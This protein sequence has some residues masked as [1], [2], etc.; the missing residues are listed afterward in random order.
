[1]P[2]G[3]I[4][5]P[6]WPLFLIYEPM[7]LQ[8]CHLFCCEKLIFLPIA[9]RFHYQERI[10]L[11]FGPSNFQFLMRI[12]EWNTVGCFCCYFNRCLLYARISAATSPFI[13]LR[14][15]DSA[16]TE[17]LFVSYVKAWA[18]FWT[19][20]LV[21]DSHSCSQSAPDDRLFDPSGCHIAPFSLIRTTAA[22]TLLQLYDFDA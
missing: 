11:L 8:L 22:T 1:M 2:L 3:P 18:T 17:A 4:L 21:D 6:S 20:K 10:S 12:L 15:A 7:L 16:L 5:L 13:S 9:D 19:H 14:R